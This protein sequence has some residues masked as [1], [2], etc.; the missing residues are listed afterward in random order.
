MPCNTHTSVLNP[1]VKLAYAEDKWDAEQL[2]DAVSCLEMAVS[3]FPLGFLV[4]LLT[5]ITV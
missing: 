5:L 2:A 3:L 1:N 4:T